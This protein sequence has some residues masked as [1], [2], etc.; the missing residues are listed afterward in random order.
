MHDISFEPKSRGA[1]ACTPLTQRATGSR[2]G[3][4][5]F[6]PTMDI[7]RNPW[8]AVRTVNS[9]G[10]QKDMGASQG[11]FEPNSQGA[12]ACMRNFRPAPCSREHLP[13]LWLVRV[14]QSTSMKAW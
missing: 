3:K 9:E 11:A 7:K 1:R 8:Y 12:H 10:M 5:N 2:A 13:L 4:F 6:R 14:V